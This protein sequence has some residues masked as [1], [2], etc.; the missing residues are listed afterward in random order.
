MA[1]TFLAAKGVDLGASRVEKRK[2]AAAKTALLKAKHRNV[3][4]H[5]PVDHV[6]VKTISED[7]E[8]MVA[9]NADFP[10]D[11]MAVD[12]GPQSVALFERVIERAKTVFWNGPM[13]IFEMAPFASGTNGVAGAIARMNG[14]SVVGGGD[15]ILALKNS[16]H[17]PF[18]SHVSTGGGA[19]LQFVEGKDLPG[20]EALRVRLMEIED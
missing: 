12:I 2:L 6:V 7:A 13:G 19:S 15:S 14:R 11:G 16:G 8:T 4:V 9:T 20:L 1:N 5:L 3:N 18:V 17:L 10:A